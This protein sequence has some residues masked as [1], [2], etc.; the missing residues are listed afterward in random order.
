MLQR[1]LPA[2]IAIRTERILNLIQQHLP[3]LLVSDLIR[4]LYHII[5]VSVHEQVLY[6]QLVLLTVS[7]LADAIRQ[8]HDLV[9]DLEELR[10]VRAVLLL[11]LDDHADR[12]LDE[13]ASVFLDG[14]DGCV[15]LD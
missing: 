3:P 4:R 15:A 5:G 10:L 14:H 11:H 12:V 2:C 9:Q 1:R 7:L 13:L 6:R 8:V